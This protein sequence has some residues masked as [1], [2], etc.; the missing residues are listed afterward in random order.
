VTPC[1]TT[2]FTFGILLCAGGNRLAVL[3]IPLL[4][5]VIGG[6]A[7]VLWQVPQDYGLIAAGILSLISLIAHPSLSSPNEL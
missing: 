4:W 2:I 5:S 3:V 6:S 7:A 1:P